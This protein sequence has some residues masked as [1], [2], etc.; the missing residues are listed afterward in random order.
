MARALLV[1]D[2]GNRVVHAELVRELSSIQ[3]VW[4]PSAP[5]AVWPTRV[6]RRLCHRWMMQLSRCDT[7]K[8]AKPG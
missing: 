6:V 8:P 7:G 5:P 3:T 1:L 4:P 2:A